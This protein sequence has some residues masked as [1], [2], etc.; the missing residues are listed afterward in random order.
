M[1]RCAA[2]FVTAAY[3]HIRLVS[4]DL[5]ALPAELLTKPF[6]RRHFSTIYEFFNHDGFVK[7][8]DAQV[9]LHPLSWGVR[10]CTLHPS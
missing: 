7:S 6:Q 8:P 5:R 2:S 4:Q 3:V 9:A 10:L 1:L